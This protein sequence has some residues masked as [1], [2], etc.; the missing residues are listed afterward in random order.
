MN[1]RVS[2]FLM[3]VCLMACSTQAPLPTAIAA[4]QRSTTPGSTPGEVPPPDYSGP[5]PLEEPQSDVPRLCQLGTTCL[6]MDP[7]PFEL[8]L[9]SSKTCAQKGVEALPVTR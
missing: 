3:A 2:L 5:L 4:A 1:T 6:S 8:C 7:R 9:L